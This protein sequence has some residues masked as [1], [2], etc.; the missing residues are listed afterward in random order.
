MSGLPTSAR[1][2]FSPLV[3]AAGLIP[4]ASA[5]DFSVKVRQITSGPSSHIFGYIGH[6]Q[7]I[8]WNGNG[9]YIIALRTSVLDRLPGAK[10]AADVVLID[11][12]KDY[13]VRV[14]DQCRAWNPQQGT[15]FYWNPDAPNTQFF[16]NDRDPETGKVFCVL[17]DIGKGSDGKRVREYRYDDTPVGNGG[18]AQNGGHFLAINYGRMARLRP[19]TGYRDAFDWTAGVAHPKDDGIFKIDIAT[20]KK[21]LLVSFHQLAESLRA[22]MPDVEIPPL[23]INHTLWNRE[24]DRIFFF[25]RGGWDGR[26]QKINQAYTIRPD[27]TDLTPLAQ[28]IGGHPEWDKGGRLIGRL[29]NRQVIYDPQRQEVVAQ[30][31]SPEVFPNPEGDIALSPDGEWFVNGYKNTRE[32]K[33]YYVIYRRKDGGHVRSPGFDIGRL[34]GDLRLDPAPCWNRDGSK[35][36][37]PGLAKDG[38]RQMFV[39]EIRPIKRR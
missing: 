1:A 9:R 3:L 10:D 13:S 18:V 38:S 30:L 33:N 24:G 22:K 27:G 11:T 28:H 37:V 2:I 34:S 36:L 4:A 7:N 25:A 32:G 29:G 6:V 15:M 14:V 23:F 12:E 31:G 26:G 35:L 21:A 17:F 5:A 19:V 16:F 8:P 20:G 39:I